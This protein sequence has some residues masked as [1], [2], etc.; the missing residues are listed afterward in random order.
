VDDTDAAVRAVRLGRDAGD[1]VLVK[2]SRLVGP[3]AGRRRAAAA[4]GACVVIAVLIAV[5]VAFV[6]SVIGTPFLIRLLRARNIG[7]A[8]RDDGPIAHPHEHKAGTPTMG[9]LAI[10]VAAFVGYLASHIRTEAI[11]F[12]DTAIALWFLILGLAFVGWLD[13]YLG[14]R[15][16][17]N[18]GLRKR[19]KTG[20]ILIVSAGFALLGPR[21]REGL[22]PPLVHAPARPRPRDRRVDPLGRRGRLRDVERGEH[23][24]RARRSRRGLGRAGVRGVRRHRLH[25]VPPPARVRAPRRRVDRRRRGRGRAHG[26]V[27]RVPLVERAPAK[28]FMGDTGAL[29]LGGAMAGMGCSPRPTSSCRSSAA[30]TCSRSRA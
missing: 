8:I 1:A 30:S 12:A 6:V 21:V 20:G 5:S 29:A 4:P 9:G 25:A 13:D 24:R 27:R 22:D 28:V 10:I 15:R 11:K 7:Q 23:H 3:R 14:V 18:L 2:A 26:C 16:A 19:G 17:R